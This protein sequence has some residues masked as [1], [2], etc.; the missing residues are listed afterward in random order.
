[1]P[2]K[3][4]NLDHVFRKNLRARLDEIDLS[5]AQL[6]KKLKVSPSYIS[7]ILS[8]H[9]NAGLKS[10]QKIAKCLDVPAL[11]LLQNLQNVG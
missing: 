3:S 6:A 10:V 4:K 11:S 1:M 5:A 8:G 2:A 7:Q 9:R